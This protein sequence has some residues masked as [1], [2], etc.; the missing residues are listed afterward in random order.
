MCVVKIRNKLLQLFLDEKVFMKC[1]I[2]MLSIFCVSLSAMH[3]EFPS[4][5]CGLTHSQRDMLQGVED[6]LIGYINIKLGIN[7][8]KDERRVDPLFARLVKTVVNRVCVLQD[9]EVTSTLMNKE[10]LELSEMRKVNWII[11]EAVRSVLAERDQLTYIAK[12]H[13]RQPWMMRPEFDQLLKKRRTE[14]GLTE[15][16]KMHN[17]IF[18]ELMTE[19]PKPE[20]VGGL[21][22]IDS[23][24]GQQSRPALTDCKVLSSSDDSSDENVSLPPQNP[25]TQRY[26]GEE[27]DRECRDFL[28]PL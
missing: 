17:T 16:H 1:F 12:G 18:V 28:M 26:H 13:T 19:K 5:N 8:S 6:S 15:K 9:P 25:P 11:N 27:F 4:N 3:Q 21:F 7:Y 24:I 20:R 14:L 22:Y 2:F 23:W 10:R